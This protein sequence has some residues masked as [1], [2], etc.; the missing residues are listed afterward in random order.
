MESKLNETDH[1]RDLQ[2]GE[3]RPRR[4][5]RR[6]IAGMWGGGILLLLALLIG[7]VVL[8]QRVH[9][10]PWLRDRV[11]ARLES[12]TGGL[13]VRFG[14]VSLVV[15]KDWRP[16]LRLTD[17]SISDADDRQIAQVSDMQASLAM[18]PLLRGQ[19]RAKRIMLN[20]AQIALTRDQDGALSLAVGS[21]A[22]RSAA[23]PTLP[24]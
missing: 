23:R 15:H 2:A 12:A 3:D 6:R 8:G 17:V 21:A 20:G 1:D 10:P 13:Q 4:R 22:R 11:E 19:V 7:V 18:R 24:S 9:A 16:R 5:S 14:D